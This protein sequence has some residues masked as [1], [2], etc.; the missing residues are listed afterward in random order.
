MGGIYE[1]IGELEKAKTEYEIVLGGASVIDLFYVAH[2]LTQ[3]CR[4]ISILQA[5]RV[6]STH[7]TSSRAN[8]HSRTRSPSNAR[9]VSSPSRTSFGPSTPPAQANSPSKDETT[10]GHTASRSICFTFFFSLHLFSFVHAA[11]LIV[12]KCRLHIHMSRLCVIFCLSRYVPLSSMPPLL[13]KGV[14]ASR[15]P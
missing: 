12:R 8:T 1:R 4:W 5:S 11:C 6:N 7:I 10:S 14:T 2:L 3:D 13:P 9:Q 15:P